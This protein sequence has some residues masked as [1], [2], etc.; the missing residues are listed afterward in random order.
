MNRIN[1]TVTLFLLCTFLNFTGCASSVPLTL[2]ENKPV[3]ESQP[4]KLNDAHLHFTNFVQESDGAEALIDALDFAGVE[5]VVLF[6][7]PVAKKWSVDDPIR[8]VYYNDNDSKSYYFTLADEI[9]A[10]AVE[11]LPEE[12]QRRIHPFICAFNP[13]DR[14][15]IRYIERTFNW[16]PHFWQGIG[17][18]LTRHDD[19]T[20]M[21]LGEVSR[22]DHLAMDSVYAFAAEHDLPV[23]LH[24]NIGTVGV[25]EPLYLHEVRKAVK[26]HPGTR[27]VWCH[28]GYSRHLEI[29][30]LREDAEK[31]LAEFN[32]LWVDLSW[33]VF[34]EIVAPGGKLDTAWVKLISRY[35]DR[36][37]LGSDKL[38]NFGSL[39]V[40]RQ[41]IR[42]Y[43]ILLQELAPEVARKVAQSN[44][45]SV[46][47]AQH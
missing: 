12:Q 17:E 22:A 5:E 1:R 40:Y 18:V 24:S 8:P 29:P 31:M 11:S 33:I 28:V 21:T 4:F 15:A 9:L 32:N 16:R 23:W 19:L 37:L 25:K 46:L 20:R 47:P 10:R 14:N 3:I 13:T 38:G 41:T 42:K 44:L 36:F 45:Y 26:N 43:D 6:G 34:E 30:T 27:F 2:T 35:P 7:L 39:E